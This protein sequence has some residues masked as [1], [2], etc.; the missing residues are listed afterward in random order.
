MPSSYLL[1]NFIFYFFVLFT[2]SLLKVD[3]LHDIFISDIG[4]SP[5]QCS[6]IIQVL[7]ECSGGE[8]IEYTYAKQAFPCRKY[9]DLAEVCRDP[10][11]VACSSI[12]YHYDHHCQKKSESNNEQKFELVLKH[13]E[14]HVVKYDTKKKRTKKVSNA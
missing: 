12:R 13:K 6:D 14:P 11:M 7:E 2:V 1:N 8:Y 5:T 4:L 9:K 3:S 10:V